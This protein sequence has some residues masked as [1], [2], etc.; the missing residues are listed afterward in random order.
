MSLLNQTK[1]KLKLVVRILFYLLPWHIT[2]TLIKY[3][4]T[5]KF[6]LLGNI[7]SSIECEGGILIVIIVINWKIN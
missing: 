3:I 4:G 5:I 2:T 7:S 1:R 6:N